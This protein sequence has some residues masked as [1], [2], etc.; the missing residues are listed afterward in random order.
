MDWLWAEVWR[1]LEW[2]S[3]VLIAAVLGGI[4]GWERERG[5]RP[6]GFRTFT[7]VTIAS[8]MF[9]TLSA[10]AF[11]T[12]SPDRIA[13]NIVVG[14]GFLGAGALLRSDA[15]DVKGLTT[16]ATLWACAAIGMACG[17][18]L[19]LLALLATVLIYIVLTLMKRL[20]SRR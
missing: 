18:Q 20:E 9:T 1:Q 7:I 11:T 19:Y 8:C 14:I 5:S 15:G 12:V 16:A 2:A 6:A 3:R 17:R 10:E 13:S 4:I